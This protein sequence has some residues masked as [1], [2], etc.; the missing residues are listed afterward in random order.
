MHIKRRITMAILVPILT[1]IRAK[2]IRSATPARRPIEK[3]QA[4]E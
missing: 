1:G 4:A 2:C 3:L